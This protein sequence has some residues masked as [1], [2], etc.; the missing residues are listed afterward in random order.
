[1]GGKR[2]LVVDDSA[3]ARRIVRIIIEGA[4]P[5]WTIVEAATGEEA[6]ATAAANPPDFALVD[7][8]MPGIDGLTAARQLLRDH[9]RAAIALLTANIQEPIRQ[10]AAAAGIGFIAKPAKTEKILDFLDGSARP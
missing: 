10:Q 6:V 5:D 2:V 4:H 9:P 8:N 1:M 3:F 7:M